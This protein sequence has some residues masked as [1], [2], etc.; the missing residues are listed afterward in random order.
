MQVRQIF[1]FTVGLIFLF[2]PNNAFS[3]TVTLNEDGEKIVV[4]PDGSWHFYKEESVNSTVIT[5]HTPIDNPI[6][7]E[8]KGKKKK[9]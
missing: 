7:T 3:Q 9:K 6:T 8:P 2:L 4:Y 1:F 5:K